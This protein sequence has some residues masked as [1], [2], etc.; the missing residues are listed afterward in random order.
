[1]STTYFRK[2]YYADVSVTSRC[3]LKCD[4]CSASAPGINSN[5]TQLELEDINRIF[6]ELDELEVLRVSLEG[7][8]PFLR[9]D[10]LDIMK[11]A[12]RYNFEYYV[13]TNATLITRKI[14][15]EI[16]RTNVS[17]LC[18]SIDGPNETIHDNC[19]GQKGAFNKTISAIK[20]LQEYDINI[21]GII[22]LSKLNSDYLIE[23]IEFI[24]SLNISN[25]AIMLLASVGHASEN[26]SNVY[27]PFDE[28][29]NILLNLTD[30]RKKNL[31]TPNVNIVSTGESTCPW[32]L[33][34]PL[35]NNNRQ[36]DIN[37][38]IRSDAQTNFGVDEFFCTAG[39]DNL[40]IDGLGNVYGCS[41]MVSESELRAGNILEKSLIDIWNDS[42]I[43]NALRS[44]Q[45]SNIKGACASCKLLKK[46]G[47]GCRACAFAL[48]K[49]IHYSDTRCPVGG[50]V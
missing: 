24:S 2:P 21:D 1:M 15:K 33:Y 3:N 35:L 4:F 41:L 44:N 7:G 49:D 10:F 25:V 31:I 18:I 42:D 43:F 12:D 5:V 11:L 22:T 28:W 34:L 26:F 23:T 29:S 17:K 48:N 46:C 37:M 50:I 13:N 45:L 16:S 38:W 14:A 20:N 9:T 30:L 32:E 19:R 6:Q 39:K 8:E 47:G 27:L 36:E 40:A